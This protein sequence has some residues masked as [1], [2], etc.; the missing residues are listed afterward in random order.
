M[1]VDQAVEEGEEVVVAAEV[2]PAEAARR[3]LHHP[4]DHPARHLDQEEAL[5]AA[6]VQ[7]IRVPRGKAINITF[8][9]KLAI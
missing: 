3:A 5:E 9:S 4:P 8:L 6:V 2:V 1:G 7:E